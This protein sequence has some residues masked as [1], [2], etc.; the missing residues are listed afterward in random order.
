M[1]RPDHTSLITDET[2]YSNTYTP[3]SGS[4]DA[5]KDRITAREWDVLFVFTGC[6]IDALEAVLSANDWAG[7]EPTTNPAGNDTVDWMEAVWG[8]PDED[9]SDVTY[10]SGEPVWKAETVDFDPRD[11]VGEFVDTTVGDVARDEGAAWSRYLSSTRPD[12]VGDIGTSQAAPYVVHFR[13]PYPPFI[14]N[15]RAGIVHSDHPIF[16][17]DA[18]TWG[19]SALPEEG[20]I[21]PE[22]YRAAY[23]DNVMEV[24]NAVNGFISNTSLSVAVTADHGTLLSSPFT[25]GD[26]SD[27]RNEIVPWAEP[28]HDHDHTH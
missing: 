20:H 19:T 23:I 24:W 4:L 11:H 27:S 16:N 12:V 6:R 26:D 18:A 8:D 10:V 9:W 2:E 21:T 1:N 15:L 17:T 14:G 7:V 13:Q 3:D 22:M 5:Q 28:E 25:H